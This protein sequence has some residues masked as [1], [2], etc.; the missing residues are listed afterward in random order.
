MNAKAKVPVFLS[1]IAFSLLSI[2]PA[3]QAIA[4]ESIHHIS[5]EVCQTCH[6]DIPDYV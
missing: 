1:S 4:D 2:L 6:K 5:S 3:I